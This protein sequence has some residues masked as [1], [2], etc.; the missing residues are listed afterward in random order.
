[1]PGIRDLNNVWNNIKEID[2]RPIA[3]AAQRPVHLALVGRN[4]AILSSLADDLRCD[5]TRPDQVTHTP[6]LLASPEEMTSA[7]RV[8]LAILLVDHPAGELVKEAA[9][10]Q[11][12]S[13]SGAPVLVILLPVPF[14]EG[15]VIPRRSLPAGFPASI[16]IAGAPDDPAFLSN[17]LVPAVIHLLPDQNI[18]LARQFPLFRQAVSKALISDTCF[19]NATYALST[20]LAEI[21]PVFN[22]PLNITDM[23][24]LTKAQ[25]FLVYRLGLALGLSTRWQDYVAEFGSVL[26]GGFVWRQVARSLIGLIPA[27]GIIPKVAV[28]YSGTYVV[29]NVVHQWYLTGR[30]LSGAQ[31]RQLYTQAFAHGK[32]LARNMATRLPKSKRKQKQLKSGEAAAPVAPVSLE[33]STNLQPEAKP[34]R[35]NLLTRKVKG[36]VCTNCGKTSAKDAQFCQYCGKSF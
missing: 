10:A 14:Q 34:A 25:A 1:M 3:E 20:G 31:M 22:V 23:V 19:S 4:S 5:P 2:L 9:L 30:H 24:V 28:A 32:Q 15:Q 16:I 26:G 29:G 33:P 13:N 11:S 12:W 7:P 6:L 27:W 18:A 17:A 35:R 21:V 36:V 8:D